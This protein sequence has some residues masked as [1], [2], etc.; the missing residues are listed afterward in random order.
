MKFP[1]KCFFRKCDQIRKKLRIWSYLRKKSLLENIILVQWLLLSRNLLF[2]VYRYFLNN[3]ISPNR[4]Y[5]YSQLQGFRYPGTVKSRSSLL[6]VFLGKG[7]RKI[8]SKITR[9]HPWRS[10]IS[11]KLQSNFV[12]IT[13]WHVCSPVH[14]LHIFRTPFRKTPM[15]G[16]FWK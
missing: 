15:E 4:K 3:Y 13:L 11:I 6:E 9:E 16:C 8:C 10:A 7:V 5:F 14:L 2:N 1:I 12:E